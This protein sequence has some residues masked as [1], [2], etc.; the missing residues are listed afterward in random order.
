M[1]IF[2]STATIVATGFLLAMVACDGGGMED[3]D[4]EHQPTPSTL[5]T[6]DQGLRWSA[7]LSGPEPV[8]TLFDA[9]DA[10]LLRIACEDPAR[11]V[12]EVETFHPVGSEERLSFGVDGEPFVFVADPTADR[13]SGVQAE[14][15]IMDELLGRFES[16]REVS[17]VYGAQS[18]G[19]YMPP[20]PE[21]ARQFVAGCRL[22]Q[23]R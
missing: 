15:P 13:R 8:L 14:A 2:R 9:D 17:A 16:A 22:L 12:L 5:G 20:D 6:I 7:Q 1:N 11:M 21:S 23:N 4:S 10:P 19:P 3:G 18:F